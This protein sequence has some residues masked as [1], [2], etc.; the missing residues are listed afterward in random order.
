MNTEKWEAIA[1]CLIMLAVVT[2]FIMAGWGCY[3]EH[4][5]TMHLRELLAGARG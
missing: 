2:L 5:E 1:I 4:I 3:L